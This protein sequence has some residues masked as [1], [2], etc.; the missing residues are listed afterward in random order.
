MEN[1]EKNTAI[2]QQ[3]QGAAG[4][5]NDPKAEKTFTQAEVDQIVQKRLARTKS[6]QEYSQRETE[7]AK[8]ELMLDAREALADAGLP[9]DLINAI[10][11]TDKE[12]MMN[13][14]KAIQGV[15]KS[16]QSSGKDSEKQ[17]TIVLPCNNPMNHEADS[18]R[19]AMG[20][21]R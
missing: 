3:E 20:L 14:I 5:G 15:I 9:K 8:R 18:I 12:T 4:T 16:G 13:S 10:N 1:M 7:L 11:C 21:K 19:Y 6:E 17:P 2:D